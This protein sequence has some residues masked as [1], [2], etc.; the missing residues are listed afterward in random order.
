MEPIPTTAKNVVFSRTN[1]HESIKTW[2]SVVAI[3]STAKYVVFSGTN[4]HDSKKAW[5]SLERSHDSKKHGFLCSQFPQ[6]QKSG[7]I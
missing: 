1:S 5:S 7:L 4:S 3:P 2:S 6:Q